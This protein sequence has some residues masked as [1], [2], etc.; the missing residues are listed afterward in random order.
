MQH[1][2]EETPAGIGKFLK[3][4][5]L[6]RDRVFSVQDS[7]D[8]KLDIVKGSADV[9]QMKRA[10]ETTKSHDGRFFRSTVGV[11]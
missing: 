10:P 8:P 11:G 3:S 1:Y 9:T 6:C 7:H 5:E 4:A 2:G